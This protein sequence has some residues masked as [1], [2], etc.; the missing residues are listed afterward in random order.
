MSR[1]STCPV[2]LSGHGQTM[3]SWSRT[4]LA[5][6]PATDQPRT[7]QYHETRRSGPGDTEQKRGTEKADAGRD[8]RHRCGLSACRAIPGIVGGTNRRAVRGPARGGDRYSLSRRTCHQDRHGTA[9]HGRRSGRPRRLR[10][11]TTH[12]VAGHR[13]MSA[14]GRILA[15]FRAARRPLRLLGASG[16]LGYGIPTPG[17]NTGLQRKPDLI[18]CDMGSI[19]IGPTYLGKGEMATSP[20]ATARDLR[21]VLLAARSLDVP[22]VIGSAGSA[23]A[24]PHLDA[25]LS[26]IRDIARA[27]GLRFR[28]AVIR[29]DLDRRMLIDALRADHIVSFDDMPSLTEADIIE[30]AHIVGQMGTGVFR[31]A[32]EADVDVVIAGR[33]CDTGIFA[34]LPM[35]LGFDAG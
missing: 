16:Q 24:A 1:A 29:A 32:L 14:S 19:D 10:R 17:F 20:E 15:E 2:A 27:E 31:R 4:H 8:V 28:M 12:A 25:T 7:V 22:L 33:A 21:K 34:A 6:F 9:N 11:A 3:A 30:A 5:S 35:L 23:G 18:G 26:I 13:A